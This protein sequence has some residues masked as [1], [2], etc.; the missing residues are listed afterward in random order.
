[1]SAS[2]PLS[3]SLEQAQADLSGL[4]SRLPAQG[5]IVITD[6]SKPIAK[7]VATPAIGERKLG[8]MAGSVRYI[9]PDFDAP[10]EE[11]REYM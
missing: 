3:V 7:L 11:F 5:E 2:H 8:T 6:G 1:M 4:I 10:L 9:A